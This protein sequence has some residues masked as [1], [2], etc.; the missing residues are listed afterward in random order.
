MRANNGSIMHTYEYWSLRRKFCKK[1]AKLLLISDLI[2]DEK[3]D[4]KPFF[5]NF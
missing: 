1:D 3:D 5:K 4:Y 2:H